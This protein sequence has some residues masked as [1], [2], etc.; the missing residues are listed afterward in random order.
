MDVF[1]LA[2]QSNMAGRGGV[3]SLPDGKA[4]FKRSDEPSMW[5]TSGQTIA[6]SL[7]LYFIS[8]EAPLQQSS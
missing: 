8:L 4:Y 5:V 3:Q 1:I 2:G 6:R 7:I